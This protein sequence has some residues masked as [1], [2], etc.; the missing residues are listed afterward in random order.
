MTFFEIMGII[1]LMGM[2][3]IVGIGFGSRA[4]ANRSKRSTQSVFNSMWVY[5][6]VGQGN[7]TPEEG[8]A[9]MEGELP[10]NVAFR[11]APKK[12]YRN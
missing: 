11:I 4:A 2:S 7:L 12:D 9:L 10:S 5:E 8:A 1:F 3:F 6:Q